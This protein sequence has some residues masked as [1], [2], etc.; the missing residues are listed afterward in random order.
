MYHGLS[1]KPTTPQWLDYSTTFTNLVLALLDR[2]FSHQWVGV[3]QDN[4]SDGLPAL[5]E[6]KGSFERIRGLWSVLTAME[7]PVAMQN[8]YDEAGWF[9]RPG[10]DKIVGIP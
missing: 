1:L 3:Y 2:M 8:A 6:A 9:Y 4:P 7:P 5:F 10:I